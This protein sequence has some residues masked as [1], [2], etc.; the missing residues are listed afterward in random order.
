MQGIIDKILSKLVAVRENPPGTPS[1]LT[2]DEI[3]WLC[4]TVRK[5][6]LDQPILLKIQGSI[7][8]CGDIHG[9]YYDLLRIFE[10]C[11][12]PPETN[13]LF[14]GDY[15]D[16]GKQSIETICLLFALKVKYPDTFFL[17]RGNH[18][19]SK[20]G[21]DYE[22]HNECKLRY[23]VNIWRIFCDVFNCLPVSAIV[24]HKIFCVHGGLSP[25]LRSLDDI[26]TIPR[27]TEIPDEGLLCDLL[28]SDPDP[29][30]NSWAPNIRGTSVIFGADALAAF[31]A[32]FGFDLLCRGHQFAP[33]GVDF[34]LGASAG[35]VTVFSAANY[36]GEM[37]NRG[38][39]MRVGDDLQCSFV[40][41]DPICNWDDVYTHVEARCDCV[42]KEK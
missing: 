31:R 37:G 29:T 35:A 19:S 21:E 26:S 32:A 9:Q 11:K 40:V 6:F 13:Y 18:E 28:W 1:G 14:L 25:L 12:Y 24:N 4:Q 17:L 15:V 42:S 22:F 7:V 38:A 20:Q 23:S 2:T 36:C 3:I 10:V 16:R 8:I 27:P 41:F 39:V 34:P 33:C 30:V 5:I